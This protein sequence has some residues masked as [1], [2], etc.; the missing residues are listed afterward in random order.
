[1][2]VFTADPAE[3]RT[4]LPGLSPL[5]RR[6]MLAAD[7]A[8]FRGDAGRCV[9]L[10]EAFYASLDGGWPTDLHIP[11]DLSVDPKDQDMAQVISALAAQP[12]LA[13]PMRVG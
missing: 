6:L 11:A 1:M 3:F 12:A 8:Q 4:Q 7:R 2:H 13:E 9:D 10:I 5:S